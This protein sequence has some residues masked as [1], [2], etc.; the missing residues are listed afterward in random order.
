MRRLALFFFLFL[1]ITVFAAAQDR[2]KAD[3]K[4]AWAALADVLEN[5]AQRKVLITQ[6]R[7]LD[8]AE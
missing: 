7:Q 8:A 3:D 1:G 6:L 5:P 2:G 4:A